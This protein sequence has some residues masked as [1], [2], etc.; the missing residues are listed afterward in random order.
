MVRRTTKMPNRI[1]RKIRPTHNQAGSNMAILPLPRGF[2]KSE[3][4]YKMPRAE[5]N[6]RI[7]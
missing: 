4:K 6:L 1:R 7:S 2:Y 5:S 3:E